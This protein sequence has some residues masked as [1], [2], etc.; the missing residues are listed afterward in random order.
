LN[1]STYHLDGVALVK[2][3]LSQLSR[4]HATT[5]N[6]YEIGT[7]WHVPR[8]VLSWSMCGCW[9][10]WIVRIWAEALRELLAK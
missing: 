4:F 8:M 7:F 2:D 3:V 5:V 10:C 9:G 1:G 6:A